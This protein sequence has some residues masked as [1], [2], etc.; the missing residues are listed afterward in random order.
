MLKI[1]FKGTLHVRNIFR[2]GIL[3]A[4]LSLC[5]YIQATRVKF[6]FVE[7]LEKCLNEDF[8]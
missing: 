5:L 1:K 2:N 6:D 4:Y 7:G 3:I 8:I